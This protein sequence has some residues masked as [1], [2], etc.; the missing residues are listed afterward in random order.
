MSLGHVQ[1]GRLTEVMTDIQGGEEKKLEA[2]LQDQLGYDDYTWGWSFVHFMMETPK[3]QPKFKKFF[4]A[5]ARDKDIARTGEG[6]HRTVAGP[7]ILKAFKRIMGIDDLAA[8]EQEW[9]A[10]IK[11]LE[12]GSVR[13][14]ERAG[15]S[16][17]ST[18]REIKAEKYFKLALEKGTKNPAVFLRYAGLL[19][20]KDR[21]EEAVELLKK[22][23]PHD[24]L[25]AQMYAALGRATRRLDGEENQAQGKR[26]LELARELDPDDVEHELHLE[27]AVEMAA[28]G[29]G[30]APMDG[31]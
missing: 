28:E 9:Y 6:F 24:P 22:G 31:N 16:A 12:F 5:I 20:R 18:G 8:L 3:Y 27:E 25:N 17:L 7:E 1:D 11:S 4:L 14:Y 13:G 30:D 2:Y 10:H 21:A 15:L 29:A 23:L 26:W 19:T